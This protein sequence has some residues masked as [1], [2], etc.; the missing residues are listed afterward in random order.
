M[1]ACAGLLDITDYQKVT[2]MASDLSDYILLVLLYLG[3]T[4]NQRSIS[5]VHFLIHILFNCTNV[6]HLKR[7]FTFS[8][9]AMHDHNWSFCF[10]MA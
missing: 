6:C 4:T 7:S 9:D 10:F 2:L 1:Q 8:L 3:C 5:S